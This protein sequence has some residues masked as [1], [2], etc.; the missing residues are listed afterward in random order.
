MLTRT[1]AAVLIVL[2]ASPVTAPF[3]TCDLVELLHSHCA[4]ECTVSLQVLV[5]RPGAD[6]EAL[7]VPP[8]VTRAGHI[9]VAVAS[10]M[11]LVPAASSVALILVAT[12]RTPVPD[13]VVHRIVPRTASVLRV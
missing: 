10:A 11:E 13:L 8:L 3:A 9:R 12:A 7:V 2:A 1:C 5:I 6:S 4:S